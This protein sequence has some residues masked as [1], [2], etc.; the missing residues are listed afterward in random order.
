VQIR[1]W[2]RL[3]GTTV[4]QQ[5]QLMMGAMA[6]PAGRLSW[7]RAKNVSS[8]PERVRESEVGMVSDLMGDD[9]QAREWRQA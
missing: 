5:A 9:Q 4:E 6:G 8:N 7:R 3:A 2:S 1:G